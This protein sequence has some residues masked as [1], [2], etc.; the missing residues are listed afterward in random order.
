MTQGGLVNNFK[1]SN[2]IILETAG[3]I[4]ILYKATERYSKGTSNE[5][6]LNQGGALVR[7]LFVWENVNEDS[8]TGTSKSENMKLP[9]ESLYKIIIMHY[10]MALSI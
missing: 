6:C 5:P 10:F 2:P 1:H 7:K 9:L 8:Y 3:L 4:L